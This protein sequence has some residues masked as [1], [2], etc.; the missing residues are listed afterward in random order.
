[1]ILNDALKDYRIIL[2]SQ[3]PRR[4]QLLTDLGLTLTVFADIDCDESYPE[5]LPSEE[6]PIYL[7][8]KK[9]LAYPQKIEH[10]EIL[11]TADTV[12]LIDG[13]ILGKPINEADAFGMLKMLSGNKH[14]VITGVCLKDP[15][16]MTSFSVV[17]EVYFKPLRDEE[18]LYYISHYQPFDKAGA[19]GAQEWIGFMGIER[20]EGSYFNVMGLPVQQLYEKLED[21][22]NE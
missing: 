20:I 3:S 14:R 16:K 12:V 22:I 21:F 8:K 10:N 18:I 17:S 15:Y 9:A 1:M 13:K 19:Y 5:E 6:I 4:K 2:A 11:I 7:A